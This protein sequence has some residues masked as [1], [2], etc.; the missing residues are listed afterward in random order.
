MYKTEKVYQDLQVAE[1]INVITFYRT[2]R[3]CTKHICP[4]QSSLSICRLSPPA[5]ENQFDRVKLPQNCWARHC[6]QI[7]NK[8]FFLFMIFSK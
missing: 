5:S 7:T 1:D 6:V 2:Q 4:S 3:D 8:R